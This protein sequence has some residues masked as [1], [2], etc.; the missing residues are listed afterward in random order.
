M[1]STDLDMDEIFDDNDI[2]EDIGATGVLPDLPEA[3]Q[4]QNEDEGLHFRFY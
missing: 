3:S 1:E 2:D 4:T